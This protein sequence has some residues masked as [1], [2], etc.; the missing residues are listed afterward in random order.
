VKPVSAVAVALCLS[1]CGDAGSPGKDVITGNTYAH[2][3]FQ[4]VAV[5]PAYPQADVTYASSD[6]FHGLQVEYFSPDGKVY[7]W[8]PGNSRSVV[9]EWTAE[10]NELCFRYQPN[11]Y[12]PVTGQKGGKWECRNR[13]RQR[14]DLVSKAEGD[15]FQLKSG[16]VP[17]H[18]LRTCRLPGSMK[19]YVQMR[20]LPKA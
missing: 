16:R 2:G 7:L 9:G 10:K 6:F 12:N 4:I 18:D 1:A 3:V 19:Q 13:A 8:Y 17:A 11:S 5:A 20:C 14:G 15:P